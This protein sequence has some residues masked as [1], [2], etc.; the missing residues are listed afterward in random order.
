MT[1]WQKTKSRY[2]SIDGAEDTDHKLL[3]DEATDESR[4]FAFGQTDTQHSKRTIKRLQ[5]II[6]ALA[7][8]LLVTCFIL[9]FAIPQLLHEKQREVYCK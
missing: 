5:L 8:L 9:L 3:E 4:T 7:T 1:F 2:T 6:W